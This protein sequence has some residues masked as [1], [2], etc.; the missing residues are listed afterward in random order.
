[1]SRPTLDHYR[2]CA[3]AWAWSYTIQPESRRYES[4]TRRQV[5]P[6][7]GIRS[8]QSTVSPF[9]ISRQKTQIRATRNTGN[10]SKTT[11]AKFV[12]CK[13]T[14]SGGGVSW[15]PFFHWSQGILFDPTFMNILNFAVRS[16]LIKSIKSELT[17]Y[18]HVNLFH[19][20]VR[21]VWRLHGPLRPEREKER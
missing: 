1:M 12:D 5:A 17:A 13:I 14:R 4:A 2:R 15:T 7:P 16:V 10:S 21:I 3:S 19:T 11:T 18:W 8:L 6:R 20:V 9:R